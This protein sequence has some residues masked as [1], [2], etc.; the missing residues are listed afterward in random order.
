MVGMRM[1][2]PRQ[3]LFSAKSAACRPA[4]K[5]LGRTLCA[6]SQVSAAHQSS[7]MATT[8]AACGT[9]GTARSGRRAGLRRASGLCTACRNRARSFLCTAGKRHAHVSVYHEARMTQAR[10]RRQGGLQAP[11]L[12]G[13]RV[14][15]TKRRAAR[16]RPKRASHMDA[17]VRRPPP[18]QRTHDRV[19]HQ[20]QADAAGIGGRVVHAGAHSLRVRVP[21]RASTLR[22]PAV[23]H[24]IH[25][26]VVSG[27]R[28]L[29][30]G[31]RRLHKPGLAA[32]LVRPG[33]TPRWVSV[34]TTIIIH[35]CSSL[36][37]DGCLVCAAGHAEHKS[38]VQA[39]YKNVCVSTCSEEEGRRIGIIHEAGTVLC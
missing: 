35:G 17:P 3:L 37:D 4:C 34:S 30:G 1:G 11:G 18:P 2:Q 32:P 38:R 5:H 27:G 14:C 7:G 8:G 26:I 15:A 6:S 31:A 16:L 28:P 29:R 24:Q 13:R 33:C 19:H 9:Q 20:L 10:R 25:I 23:L 12:A 36:F 21:V 22:R 39:V